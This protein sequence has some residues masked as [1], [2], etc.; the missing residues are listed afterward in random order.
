VVLRWPLNT[1]AIIRKIKSR[2]RDAFQIL[3]TGTEQRGLLTSII[4]T[5]RD[6]CDEYKG[7]RVQEIVKCPCEGCQSGKNEQHFFDFKN[8]THRLEKGRRIVECDKSLEDVDLLKLLGSLFIFEPILIGQKVELKDVKKEVKEIKIFLASSS[9]LVVDRYEFERYFR[10]QNDHLKDEKGI[11]LKIVQWEN[12]L[13]AMSET[14]LQGEYNKEVKACDIFVS[15]FFT[16]TGKYT[17]EEFNVA[18]KQFLESGGKK[19]QIFTFFKNA[20]INTGSMNPDDLNTLFSFKKKLKDLGHYHTQY[21]NL[22][23]LKLKF[24]NQLDLLIRG[25]KV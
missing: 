4:K 12:F 3:V 20:V 2:G 18:R 19:P 16:K 5:L 22:P 23:D 15:L 21:D 6:L 14:R 7:I 10:Q 8:L 25:A 24:R 1:R 9:E 11:Y 13:D 17:E